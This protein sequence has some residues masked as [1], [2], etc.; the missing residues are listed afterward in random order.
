MQESGVSHTSSSNTVSVKGVSS[1]LIVPLWH[2]K[3]GIPDAKTKPLVLVET[4]ERQA[5]LVS[6]PRTLIR[7]S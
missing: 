2:L 7:L 3:S 6:L 1:G 4:Q 5:Y